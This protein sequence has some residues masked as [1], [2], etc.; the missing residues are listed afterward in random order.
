MNWFYFEWKFYKCIWLL[1]GFFSLPLLR[2]PL[3]VRGEE[4]IIVLETQK[5][6]GIL[7]V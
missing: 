3:K 4:P 7:F 2:H 6:K 5:E 1:L